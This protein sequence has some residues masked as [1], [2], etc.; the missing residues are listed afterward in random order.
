VS[1]FRKE[2]VMDEGK[3]RMGGCIHMV[4]ERGMKERRE[5]AEPS[6]IKMKG[7]LC[8]PNYNSD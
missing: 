6:L 7:T 3:D 1:Q 8:Y 4:R 2:S 5:C